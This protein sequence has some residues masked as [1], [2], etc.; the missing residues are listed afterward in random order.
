MIWMPL[1]MA[2]FDEDWVEPTVREG[3]GLNEFVAV[4]EFLLSALLG[5]CELGGTLSIQVEKGL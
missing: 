2:E 4:H 5:G 3:R 1:V